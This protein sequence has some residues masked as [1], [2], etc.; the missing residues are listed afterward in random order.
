MPAII[1]FRGREKC[2]SGSEEVVL[3]WR[4]WVGY[5]EE[6]KNGLK[7]RRKMKVRKIG[8]EKE[9]SELKE[10]GKRKQRRK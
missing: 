1:V 3:K 2:N 9:R 6:E 8:E 10:E 7:N 5:E 4:S